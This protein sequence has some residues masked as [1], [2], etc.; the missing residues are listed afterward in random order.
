MHLP[1]RR[2]HRPDAGVRVEVKGL[3]SVGR[4]NGGSLGEANRREDDGKDRLDQHI[5]DR[6][7]GRSR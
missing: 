1:S 2:V 3:A 6:M 7:S 4:K 5:E